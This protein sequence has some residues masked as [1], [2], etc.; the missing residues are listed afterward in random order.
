MFGFYFFCKLR[1]ILY[2]SIKKAGKYFFEKGGA[3]HMLYYDIQIL[4]TCTYPVPFL[5]FLVIK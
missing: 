5:E 1:I 3:S 2:R 4:I